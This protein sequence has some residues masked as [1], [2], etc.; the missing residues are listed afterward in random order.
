MGKKTSTRTSQQKPQS[1]AIP[2]E[3]N[4]REDVPGHYANQMVVI[5]GEHEFVLHFF[6][7]TPPGIFGPVEDV[8]NRLQK[9]PSIRANSVAKIIVPRAR[10]A[11][12]VEALN[13]RLEESRG[14][15][16]GD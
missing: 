4:F 9:L 8:K 7:L 14:D 13:A 15:K 12:F 10:Y 5:E 3:W 6:E 1:V 2:I 16:Q 11:K